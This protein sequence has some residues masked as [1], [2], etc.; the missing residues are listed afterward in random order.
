MKVWS[1]SYVYILSGFGAGQWLVILQNAI[2]KENNIC[3]LAIFKIVVNTHNFKLS[4][5]ISH[6]SKYLGNI[7]KCVFPATLYI[8]VFWRMT[9]TYTSNFN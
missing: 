9:V 8:A 7:K 6:F 1:K 4:H 5:G 3:N 2:H